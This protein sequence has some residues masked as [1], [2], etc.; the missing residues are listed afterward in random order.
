MR[1][2]WI[3]CGLTC[4]RSCPRG[5]HAYMPRIRVVRMQ[6]SR[7]SSPR[8]CRSSIILTFFD[9]FPPILDLQLP[10]VL[11]HTLSPIYRRKSCRCGQKHFPDPSRVQS[12]DRR[13]ESI[14]GE[15]LGCLGDGRG[16]RNPSDIVIA[17]RISIY[18][19]LEFD[20]P[21]HENAVDGGIGLFLAGLS[22][23]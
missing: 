14:D 1:V 6:L 16:Y 23:E 13:L 15:L 22:A 10:T 7:D 8:T 21:K 11:R 17:I 4:C 9:E 20:I 2:V 18:H 3:S 5:M 19:R 12:I